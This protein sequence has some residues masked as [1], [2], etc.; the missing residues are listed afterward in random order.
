MASLSA[1]NLSMPISAPETTESRPVESPLLKGLETSDSSTGVLSSSAPARTV[2]ATAEATPEKTVAKDCP[3]IGLSLEERIKNEP[4]KIL[5][6]VEAEIRANQSCA[7]EVVKSAIKASNAD[8]ALVGDIVEVAM[9]AAPDSMRLISQCAIAAAPDSLATVQAVL[10]KLDPNRGETGSSAKSAK[11]AKGDSKEAASETAPN[12]IPDP[13][14]PLN[15]P[16]MGPPVIPILIL[17]P[18]QFVNPPD[19]TDVD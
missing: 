4:S 5:E 18:G 9:T 14:N 3:T 17:P 7:C 15:L 10:A 8:T 16:P 1:Q 19:V 13:A 11:S 2:S 12:P 6:L